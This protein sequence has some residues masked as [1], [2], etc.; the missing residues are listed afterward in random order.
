MAGHLSVPAEVL[1]RGP[2][3]SRFPPPDVYFQAIW[4][5]QIACSKARDLDCG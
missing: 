5:E 2:R 1:I 4:K 3:S